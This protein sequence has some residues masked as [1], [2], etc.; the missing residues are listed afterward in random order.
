MRRT[1]AAEEKIVRIVQHVSQMQVHQNCPRGVQHSSPS[2]GH[3]VELRRF[4][5]RVEMPQLTMF[6]LP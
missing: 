6:D 4:L 2:T 5:G 1:G 3:R